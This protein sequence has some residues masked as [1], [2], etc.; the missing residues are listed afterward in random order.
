MKMKQ[1]KLSESFN[2]DVLFMEYEAG[3]HESGIKLCDIALGLI[4]VIDNRRHK[5]L[6]AK[7]WKWAELNRSCK[8]FSLLAY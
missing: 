7:V 2:A 6:A 3:K 1:R 5:T 8:N 4:P